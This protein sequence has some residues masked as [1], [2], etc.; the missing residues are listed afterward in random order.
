MLRVLTILIADLFC[1]CCC[2]CCC[3]KMSLFPVCEKMIGAPQLEYWA[4][5]TCHWAVFL[6]LSLPACFLQ[7]F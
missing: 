2:R 6:G 4:K 1:C 5:W 7:T 3:Y